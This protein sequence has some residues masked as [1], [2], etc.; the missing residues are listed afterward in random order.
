MPP[1][2]LEAP[3]S[4][5]VS[6]TVVPAGTVPPVTDEPSAAFLMSVAMLGLKKTADA[7]RARS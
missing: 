2:L 3:V 5:A 6:Y 4:V 7:S 1:A